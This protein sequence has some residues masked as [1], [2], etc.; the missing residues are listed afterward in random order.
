MMLLLQTFLDIFATDIHFTT[1][2][3]LQIFRKPLVLAGRKHKRLKDHLVR[4]D[5]ASKSI[6]AIA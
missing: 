1:F 3:T 6:H 2:E 5:I 4:A